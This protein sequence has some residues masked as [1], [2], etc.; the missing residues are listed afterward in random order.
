MDISFLDFT[1]WNV[2]VVLSGK[3]DVTFKKEDKVV[4][5]FSLKWNHD[6]VESVHNL[7]VENISHLTEL[8]EKFVDISELKEYYEE[9]I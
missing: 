6:A 1:K 4:K 5:V 8:Y 7:P 2:L 9:E 3:A